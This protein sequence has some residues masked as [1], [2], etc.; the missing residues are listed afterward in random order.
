[1]PKTL[2]VPFAPPDWPASRPELWKLERIQPY[3]NNPRTHPPEQIEQLARDMKEDGVT[4]PILVD[5]AGVIIAGHGR[6]LAAEHN[7]F[8]EYPVVIARGWT[9]TQ[10]KAARIKDNQIGLMSGWDREL[11]KTNLA[12]LKLEG[13]DLPLLGFPDSELRAWGIALGI[14]GATDPDAVPEPPKNPVVRLGDFWKLGNHLLLCGDSTNREHVQMVAG[15]HKAAMVFTDPP[16]GVAYRDTGTGAWD[17]E[18]KARKRAGLLKPRFEAIANDELTEEELYRFLVAYMTIQ[19]L[20][21]DAAQYVCHASLRAHVFREALLE[22]GMTLRSQIIW[23]KSRPGFNFAQ[24]KWKHEPIYYAVPESGTVAW[25]GDNTQT[26]LWEIAS[27]S[28]AVYEHPTQK[29]VG[30]AGKAISNSLRSGE[31]IY[32]PFSGSG[33]T[34]IACEMT[35][36][37]A[38]AIEI[39]PAYVEVAIKRWQDF[40][41]ERATLEGKPFDQV[42]K[43]RR[44]E[45]NN[46]AGDSGEP[47]SGQDAEGDAGERRVRKTLHARRAPEGR[48][49]AGEPP[50]VAG[51]S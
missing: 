12:E 19:P 4:M 25:Y 35:G 44:K 46:E 48:K 27:E 6:L 21:K 26:T 36:R 34:L 11:I 33:S 9:E 18:K 31:S 51:D 45:A 40:T 1:M 50:A 14:E 17:E 7:H 49:P 37:K 13:Y 3:P 2:D 15:G 30:L 23:A 5:E 43:A 20:R 16:Y 41:G 47:I 24:Y 28:G 32:E 22:T 39:D 29:P 38:W 10:K 8:E 42:A